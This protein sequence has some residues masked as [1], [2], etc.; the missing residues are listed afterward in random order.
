MIFNMYPE[1]L[2]REIGDAKSVPGVLGGLWAGIQVV[3]NINVLLNHI[4]TFNRF[5]F[6]NLVI[7]YSFWGYDN[8]VL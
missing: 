2:C 5:N 3:I 6:K 4:K 8:Y 7:K 1:C